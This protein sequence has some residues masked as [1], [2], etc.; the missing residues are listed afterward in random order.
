MS[1]MYYGMFRR[2]TKGEGKEGSRWTGKEPARENGAGLL[3]GL[4]EHK[5]VAGQCTLQATYLVTTACP[6]CSLNSLLALSERP[7]CLC[8]GVHVS[9]LVTNNELD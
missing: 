3:K 9:D 5:P 1:K 7:Y 8:T 2:R 6:G 4:M